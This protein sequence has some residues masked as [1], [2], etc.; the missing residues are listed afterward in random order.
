MSK[1]KIFLLP[2]ISAILL[3]LTRIALPLDFLVFV[4]FIPLLHF[5]KITS[6]YTE[7][8]SV[9][10][11]F[12]LISGSVFAIIY[13][14]IS[15]HWINHVTVGG[16]FGILFLFTVVYSLIFYL[17]I[18]INKLNERFIYISFPI[19]WLLNEFLWNFSEISFPW[20]NIAYGLKNS[21][22]LLQF[23]EFG[24]TFLIGLLILMINY[25][26]FIGFTKRRYFIAISI[27]I[28]TIWFGIGYMRREHIKRHTHEVDFIVAMIQGN[29]TQDMKW[30]ADMRD[31]TFDIYKQLSFEVNAEF[32][33]DLIIFPE[34]A[35]P[36]Y[37]FLE[38]IYMKELQ[39]IVN[40]INTPIYT[41]FPHAVRETKYDGQDSP[42]LHFNAAEL[43]RP[44]ER[45]KNDPYYKN[46]LVPF[47]ERVPLLDKFPI[48]W[49][50]QMGQANFEPGTSTVIYDVG[51]FTFA[52]LICFEI[53]FPYFIKNINKKH[54]PD[55]FVNITN[56]AWFYTSIGTIQ[57]AQMAAF[58]SIET[59]KPIF[60][61]A[62]T[63]YS[64]YTTPDGKIHEMTD[65]F[66]RTFVVGRLQVYQNKKQ[67]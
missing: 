6:G 59:R 49:R 26:L 47:G 67:N 8:V 53:A 19:L 34:A 3:G 13:L 60:R 57:H 27:A 12:A 41:G 32:N 20:F 4:A 22:N 18:K 42:F 58:R 25:L 35:L 43:F 56:D 63:G 9:F 36:V 61:V 62:N 29:I 31:T 16:F 65:L 51:E 52:P 28:I 45:P 17:V 30:E 1:L 11:Y 48:L 37:I 50:L 40:T 39:S 44:Y 10:R 55:F 15:I 24:G 23:L 66:E 38:P 14:C 46:I 5:F 64:F 21:L 2:V 7:S 54:T 33:P